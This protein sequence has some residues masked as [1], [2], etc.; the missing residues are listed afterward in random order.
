MSQRESNQQ[1]SSPPPGYQAAQPEQ[2]ADREQAI[3]DPPI[4]MYPRQPQYAPGIEPG[5]VGPAAGGDLRVADS[6][7]D[8]CLEVLNTAYAEG[9]ITA[10]EHAER[11]DAASRARIFDDLIPLTRDLVPES[12]V[13]GAELSTSGVARGPRIEPSQQMTQPDSMVAVIG[14]H[15]RTGPWRVRRKLQTYVLLGD[16]DLDFTE[17][18]FESDTIEIEGVIAMGDLNIRIPEGI[19]VQMRSSNVLGD[20]KVKGLPDQSPTGPTLVIRT[21]TIM[22]DVT[23]RGPHAQAS[24]RER[25]R[26]RRELK[27]ESRGKHCGQGH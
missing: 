21:T 14:D 22:G 9:R 6:D 10:G 11:I 19:N 27:N 5:D 12:P 15:T 13:R 17:A 3:A 25:R 24:R 16:I 18:I 4:Q 2:Q 20:S 7:R 23:V 26:R 1:W 8:L